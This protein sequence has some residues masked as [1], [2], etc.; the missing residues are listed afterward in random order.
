M[1]TEMRKKNKQTNK[2]TEGN[3][4]YVHVFFFTIIKLKKTIVD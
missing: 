3:E 2:Q 4:Y 1:E